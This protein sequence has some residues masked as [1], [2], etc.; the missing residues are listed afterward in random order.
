[1]KIN[2]EYKLY[3]DLSLFKI[4]ISP[5]IYFD[6]NEDI[7]FG[8]QSRYIFPYEYLD[9]DISL[10]EQICLTI[11]DNKNRYQRTIKFWDSSRCNTDTL[12]IYDDLER[13]ITE[14]FK[15]EMEN[16]NSIENLDFYKNDHN[17]WELHSHWIL[18]KTDFSQRFIYKK[19]ITSEM[20]QGTRF[21]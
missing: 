20:I 9:I 14:W 5:K 18:Y 7:L 1:M 17:L 15:I 3:N 10:L 4:E 2:L 8:S 16:E 11:E 13:A 12:Y 21:I 19:E 6:D